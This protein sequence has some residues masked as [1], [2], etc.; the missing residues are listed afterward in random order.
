[1]NVAELQSLM[2]AKLTLVDRG[3]VIDPATFLS[4]HSVTIMR[5]PRFLLSGSGCDREIAEHNACEM[6]LEYFT[7][8]LEKE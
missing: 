7:K 8:P 5:G 4:L 1:M 3:K 2:G 6:V